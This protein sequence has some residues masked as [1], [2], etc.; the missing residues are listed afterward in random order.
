ML[1]VLFTSQSSKE[2]GTLAGL[3]IG[4]VILLEAL[5]AGPIS[6]ASMNPIRS[7][8]P[9]IPSGNYHSIWIYLIAP[10]LGSGLATGIWRG[11]K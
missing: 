7:L 1:V 3:A 5:F 11:M 10:I 8:A 9:E 4:G 6:R 2:T